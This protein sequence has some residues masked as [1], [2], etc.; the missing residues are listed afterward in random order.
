MDMKLTDEQAQ[1][2]DAARRY[3]DEECTMAFVRRMEASELGFADPSAE[4][5]PCGDRVRGRRLV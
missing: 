2:Q 5:H 1:L 3:M 4:E